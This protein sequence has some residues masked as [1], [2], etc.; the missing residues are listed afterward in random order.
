MFRSIF[1]MP[2]AAVFQG[3]AA[4]VPDE[5]QGPE[6]R[7][8]R[9]EIVTTENGETKRITKEFDA[10]NEEEV[11]DALKELG[12]L[13]HI[14]MNGDGEN[15]TIDIRRYGGDTDDDVF[16][17]MAP[18]PPLP[19]MPPSMRG[20]AVCEPTAYLGVSTRTVDPEQAKELKLPVKSGVLVEQVVDGSAAAKAGLEEGDVITELDGKAV[21]GSEDLV[22]T[23]REQKAG[24][25]VKLTWYHAGKKKSASVELGERPTRTYTNA[26]GPEHGSAEHDWETYFGDGEWD[27]APRAFLGVTP[28]DDDGTGASIGSVEEGTAAEQMGVQEGDRITKLND[29]PITDFD[30]LSAAVKAQKPGD[31]VRV[32]VLRDGQQQVLSGKLGERSTGRAFHFNYNGDEGDEAEEREF[33]F[34]GLA[35]EDREALRRDMDALREE[36]NELR[37]DL[38]KDLRVETRITIESMPLSAE[39]KALLKSKGVEHL[40]ADL[41]VGDMRVFPNPSNGFFRIQF[42]VP[43]SGDL[44]VNVHDNTGNKVY[45][46]RITGFKGR[47]ERTLDLTDKATGT[48]FLVIDQNAKSIAQKLVKQ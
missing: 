26:Y 35:P 24:D 39:E 8:V 29:E 2:L 14:N 3:G 45:E 40:D 4:Q 22:A 33:E 37:R 38:R 13:D 28:G 11:Q 47:Y 34:H 20:M 23:I 48:Y 41:K 46:E 31:E 27:Q 1:F 17:H 16:L 44:F 19:T 21:Q 43:E 5:P 12:V 18:T 6:D 10:A 15:V 36:M 30:D 9:I 32:T 42:D 7:K 25:K